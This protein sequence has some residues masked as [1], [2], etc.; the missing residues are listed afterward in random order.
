LKVLPT[1]IYF[2]P[3][4]NDSLMGIILSCRWI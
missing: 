4:R 1:K 2:L 3:L